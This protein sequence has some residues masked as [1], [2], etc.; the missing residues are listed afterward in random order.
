M[1]HF[2]KK[3]MGKTFK[4]YGLSRA[5]KQ[6]NPSHTEHIHEREHG[7]FGPPIPL[8]PTPD[9]IGRRLPAKLPPAG[10]PGLPGFG[11]I[12]S[13]DPRM[14]DPN[15][16][17]KAGRLSAPTFRRRGGTGTA[18]SIRPGPNAPGF[19][20]LVKKGIAIR[21]VAPEHRSFAE[22]GIVRAGERLRGVRRRFRRPLSPLTRF[23]GVSATFGS[24]RRRP[25]RRRRARRRR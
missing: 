5:K 2:N 6:H 7:K 12:I 10:F 9:P 11:P 25:L 21:A 8:M 24:R 23:G 19:E 18:P 17:L 15:A 14:R 13:Q 20:R 4:S 1:K 22:R 16:R 3:R